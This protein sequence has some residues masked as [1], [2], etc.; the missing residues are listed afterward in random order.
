MISG[1]KFFF[2]LNYFTIY[3]VTISSFIWESGLVMFDDSDSQEA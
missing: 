2:K 1:K 3:L